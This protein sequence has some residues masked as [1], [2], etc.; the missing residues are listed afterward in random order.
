MFWGKLLR[1]AT[2]PGVPRGVYEFTFPSML[3][4]TEETHIDAIS[5]A[6]TALLSEH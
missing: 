6:V 4:Q 2:Y 5:Q 1:L 3:R